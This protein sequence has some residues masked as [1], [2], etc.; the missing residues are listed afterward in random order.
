MIFVDEG[1]GCWIGGGG[2]GGAT[3]GGPSFVVD[4]FVAGIEAFV[5]VEFG[6]DVV[7]RW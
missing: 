6:V 1:G 5:G 3:G 4:S 2:G 7:E